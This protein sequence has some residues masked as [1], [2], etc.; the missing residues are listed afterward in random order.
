MA[1]L[2]YRVAG[3]RRGVFALGLFGV[4]CAVAACYLFGQSRTPQPGVE[5]E[6]QERELGNLIPGREYEVDVRLINHTER[7]VRL[8]GIRDWC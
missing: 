4:G 3:L 8:L 2:R 5:V 1:N 7:Q 6:G